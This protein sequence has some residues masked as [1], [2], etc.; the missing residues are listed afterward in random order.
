M[1][2]LV[3]SWRGE[4]V[5]FMK[6]EKRRGRDPTSEEKATHRAAEEP[7][8][9][10]HPVEAGTRRVSLSEATLCL[11]MDRFAPS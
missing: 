9:E 1:S 4:L 11:L 2:G 8:R 6:K 5:R 10:S 3:E 7:R